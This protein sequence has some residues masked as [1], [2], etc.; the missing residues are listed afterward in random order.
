MARISGARPRDGTEAP[1]RSAALLAAVVLVSWPLLGTAWLDWI[2]LTHQLASGPETRPYN[3]VPDLLRTG[4]GRALL[5]GATLVALVVVGSL[6]Q[7]RRLAPALGFSA[8]LAAAPYVSAFVFY[9]YAVLV[10]P[11]LV[12]IGLGNARIAARLA[13]IASWI[14]IDLQASTRIS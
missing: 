6:V 11:V 10:L 1:R 12:W 7:G 3:V 5:V 9:P 2:R 13:A 4:A 8:A 14:L